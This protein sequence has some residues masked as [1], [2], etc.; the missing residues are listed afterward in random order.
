MRRGNLIDLDWLIEVTRREL[1]LALESGK[2]LFDGGREFYLCTCRSDDYT[3][4]YSANW[5]D[6][7]KASSAIPA[8][9]G[10]AST[11]RGSDLDGGISDAILVREA[12]A[13][14]TPSWCSAPCRRKCSTRR[15][16]SGVWSAG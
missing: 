15:N 7:I 11:W 9:T 6:L 8:S 5:Q 13:A 3:P 12:A 16:G 1:P 10:S 14:P 2:L 4:G